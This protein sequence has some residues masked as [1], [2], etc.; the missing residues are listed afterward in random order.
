ATYEPPPMY[1]TYP[2]RE[3]LISYHGIEI[4]QLVARQVAQLEDWQTQYDAY[5][6][7]DHFSE[8][9]LGLEDHENGVPFHMDPR[10]SSHS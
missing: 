8:A 10:G 2:T 3:S 9:D 4:A 5:Q 1:P 7:R 6:Q